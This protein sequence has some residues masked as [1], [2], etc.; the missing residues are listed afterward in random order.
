MDLGRRTLALKAVLDAMPGAASQAR[1]VPTGKTPL[2][3]TYAVMGKMFA[4][5]SAR[6]DE[7]VVLKCDPHLAEELREKYAGVGHR[8][9]LD[10]RYWIAVDLN[11]DVPAKEVKRLAAHSYDQ[12][13]AKLTAKQKAELAALS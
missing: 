7:F 8:S 9:H 3:L 6:A 2:V 12:V 10:P 11:A 1:S 13:C 5:L 4:V